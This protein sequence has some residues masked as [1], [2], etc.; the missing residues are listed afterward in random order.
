MI[1]AEADKY[2]SLWENETF[3]QD[4]VNLSGLNIS[5]DLMKD[6]LLKGAL[7]CRSTNQPPEDVDRATATAIVETYN[8]HFPL[9][10]QEITKLKTIRDSSVASELKRNAKGN[11]MIHCQFAI[12]LQQIESAIFIDGI[13]NEL[14]AQGIFCYTMHDAFGCLENDIESVRAI[15][16]RQLQNS[17]GYRPVLKAARK[18]LQIALQYLED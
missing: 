11:E 5:S 17:I 16:E 14:M 18:Q 13:A 10:A 6:C 3:Y 9:L 7:N 15:M 8:K 12:K 1:Q 4:F 2:Y